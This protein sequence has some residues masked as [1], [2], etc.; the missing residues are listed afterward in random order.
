MKT[1]DKRMIMIMMIAIAL[2]S[3]TFL[4]YFSN[5]NALTA[6]SSISKPSSLL[7]EGSLVGT[8]G[9]VDIVVKKKSLTT[10]G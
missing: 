8:T 10:T 2:Y 7:G 3:K 5:F 1:Y 4:S 6:H 9:S